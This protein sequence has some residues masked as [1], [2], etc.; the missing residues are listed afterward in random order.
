LIAAPSQQ[1]RFCYP[2]RDRYLLRPSRWNRCG[3]ADGET[4]T[5]L[6]EAVAGADTAIKVK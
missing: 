5:H 6:R 1:T 2:S 3:I 4:P